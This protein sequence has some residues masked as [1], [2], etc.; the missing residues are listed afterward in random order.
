VAN[1]LLITN[2]L[3]HAAY[4]NTKA[5]LES[6]GHVVTGSTDAISALDSAWAGGTFDLIATVRIAD[7]PLAWIRD[8]W[9]AGT[10][11][12]IGGMKS[13]TTGATTAEQLGMLTTAADFY[14]NTD[15]VSA[16]AKSMRVGAAHAITAGYAAGS[17]VAVLLSENF[18]VLDPVATAAYGTEI[19][20]AYG[21]STDYGVYMAAFEVGDALDTSA[22]YAPGATSPTRAVFCGWLY[23][24]QS[25]YTA[26]GKTILDQSVSW[27]TGATTP[28]TMSLAGTLPAVTGAFALDHTPPPT[29]I[30]LAGTLPMVTGTFALMLPGVATELSLVGILPSVTATA[31]INVAPF[32][33]SDD[34]FSNDGYNYTGAARVFYDPPVAATPARVRRVKVQ[35]VHQSMPIPTLV[36]GRPT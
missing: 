31:G 10:P 3:S 21:S 34:T 22:L 26:D 2:S 5:A 35:R 7:T 24:G 13:A 4:T 12:L 33:N 15:A 23:A 32:V 27:L 36:D 8:K 14:A 28:P 29:S 1:I 18:T 6:K 17:Q 25:D 16:A 11:V 19:G 9:A 30:T 20:D